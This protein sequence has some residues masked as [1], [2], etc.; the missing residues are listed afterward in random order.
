MDKTSAFLDF[1]LWLEGKGNKQAHRSYTNR[2]RIILEFYSDA[3]VVVSDWRI[4]RSGEP[5]PNLHCKYSALESGLWSYGPS[6][7]WKAES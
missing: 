5:Y 6:D 1:M 7:E 3:K 4:P 2:L